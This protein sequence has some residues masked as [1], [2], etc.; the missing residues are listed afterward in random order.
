MPTHGGCRL[1]LFSDSLQNIPV[2]LGDTQS[3]LPHAQPAALA[4]DPSVIAHAGGR[5]HAVA[6]ERVTLQSSPVPVPASYAVQSIIELHA[7]SAVLAEDMSVTA[8]VGIA[9]HL[10]WDA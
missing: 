9:R 8:Q 10:F 2:L 5:E 6:P 1:H 4:E 7:Q 3:T